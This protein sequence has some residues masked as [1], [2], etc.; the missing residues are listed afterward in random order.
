MSMQTGSIDKDG[1][2][3]TSDGKLYVTLGSSS[4]IDGSVIGGVTPAAGTF[5]TLTATSLFTEAAEDTVTAFASGGQA[6]AT[7]L[8]ATKNLHRVSVCATAADSIKLPAALAGQ[9][10]YVRNDGAAACQV[11]GQSTETINAVASAT[12]IS[13]GVG[14]GVWYVCTTAGA[15]TTSP[16][17]NITSTGQFLAADGTANAPGFAFTSDA[18][19]TGTGFYRSA[20]NEI[21]ASS[22]GT[23]VFRL[24]S[25]SLSV[26]AL[27]LDTSNLDTILARAAANSVQ[28]GGSN[29][30]GAA[31]TRVELNKAVTGI[32]NAAATDVLTVTI[33]NAAHS[34]SL[35]I[36]VTGSLGAGGAVGANEATATNTYVVSITRTAGVATVVTVSSAY[37]AAASAVA[38][39]ATVTCTAAAT[40]MTG[41]VSAT[42]TFTM[43]ATISR[44]AGSSTNHTCLVYAKL[45]N[46]NATGI[47]IA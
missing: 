12:G 5:T 6:S 45:M 22:N 19:G 18:D 26:N 14:M 36:R 32:T 40:A 9:A 4:A 25:G 30:I 34:A 38:G 41:A 27:R 37:G 2:A 43:Q 47:T 44:S 17:S 10:H 39:A 23:Q 15:W 20:A 16:V 42:Q 13:Q 33:P 21:S 46:A 8:S 29:T 7:A 3:R 1:L 11:F 31:T 28:F 24:L 35:E